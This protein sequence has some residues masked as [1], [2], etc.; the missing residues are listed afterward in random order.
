MKLT[1]NQH[2]E[3]FFCLIWPAFQPIMYFFKNGM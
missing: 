2:V 1:I 3:I